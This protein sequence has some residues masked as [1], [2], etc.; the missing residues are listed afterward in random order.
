[1][2]TQPL[3][4]VGILTIRDDEFRAVLNAFPR[5]H[6]IYR[7][8]HREYTLRTADAGEGHQ[9]TIAVLRQIEQGNGEAQ[10][11]ARDLID[12]L[13]PSLLLI[14]GIAGG[15]PSED[16]S[17]G[18]VVLSTRILDFSLEARKFQDETTYN[19]GGGPIS[20]QI[21]T[22][23]ANLSAR[24]DELGEWW[25]DL[26]P[27]PPVSFAPGKLYGSR[28][29]QK[30]VRESLRAHF[31]K[32]IPSRPPH[33]L[34]GAIAASDRLVKDPELLLPWITSAR[35]IIAVEMES[36]GVHRATRD[37]TP[38]LSIRALSDIV[39]LKRQDAWTKYACA[40]AA[41][42]AAAY[43]KTQPVPAKTSTTDPSAE[44]SINISDN[45]N[46]DVREDSLEESF[47]NLIHLRHFP[48]TL[49][50]APAHGNNRSSLW[51]QLNQDA[52]TKPREY[53]S[54]AWTVQEK[55]FYSLVDPERSRLR[56]VIDTGGLEQLETRDWAFSSD[57]N[58]RRL[59]VQ[60]L[61]GALSDDLGAQGV[62][63]FKDQDVYAFLGWPDE[64]ERSLKYQNLRVRSTVTVVAHYDRTAKNG[65]AYHYQRHSAFQGRFRL[66]G[67][68]WYL[69]ITPTYRF[70]Y[71]GKSLSRYHESLL[72][73]I[74]RFERNRSVLSQ[75]LLW[76]AVLRAPW[77]RA[78]SA[79]LLEFAPLVSIPFLSEVYEGA[80]TALDAP[81]QTPPQEK[82]IEE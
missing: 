57:P 81:A 41:A 45:Q 32:G 20:K 52:T 23:V 79:R 47:A 56:N 13:Q 77:K 8:R 39:G 61:N 40:S 50:V 10:E 51:T 12:D 49:Y 38:M 76:Q 29:W 9:Y 54:N 4:D 60:L 35:G 43:L 70:T 42:F 46:A 26:P 36:A 66:L 55:M 74:K 73:G 44:P 14:V 75:L 69:E 27:R 6:T 1:M 62:R 48:E 2:K 64:P 18:D 3:V 15:L 63:Y 22:G 11:A 19:V 37:K 82:G 30:S 58:W 17:L 59:F 80:L 21:A 71:D 78:D 33:F 28:P 72:S 68:N 34:A 16:I 24:E 65:K 67:G 25:A 5:G 31:E 7:G 53:I